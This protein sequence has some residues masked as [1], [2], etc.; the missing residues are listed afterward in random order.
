MVTDM[1]GATE[2]GE[3]PPH[4]GKILRANVHF[5]LAGLAG[6]MALLLI[7]T[8][9]RMYRTEYPLS[10]SAIERMPPELRAAVAMDCREA[11]RG[12]IKEALRQAGPEYR[13]I[14]ET[15]NDPRVR[16]YACGR[17][18]ELLAQ[19]GDYDAAGDYFVQCHQLSRDQ[20]PPGK[21]NKH[22]LYLAHGAY[23]LAGKNT[24]ELKTRAQDELEDDEKKAFFS[25]V[26]RLEEKWPAGEDAP[27]KKRRGPPK[28][29]HP[30]VWRRLAPHADWIAVSTAALIL[31]L[32]GNAKRVPLG[33]CWWA[34]PIAP[35]MALAALYCALG[36]PL[37]E[38]LAF[39]MGRFSAASFALMRRPS[40]VAGRVLTCVI[41]ASFLAPAITY[42]VLRRRRDL[43]H[44]M[45]GRVTVAKSFCWL[46]LL[47]GAGYVFRS[48]VYTLGRRMGLVHPP[49]V[50]SPIEPLSG[51]MAV[52]IVVG[53]ISLML[54]SPI[55]QE[56]VF[57]GLV[58]GA[59]QARFP[60][61]VAVILSS[62]VFAL[63]HAGVPSWSWA[64]AINYG[65]GGLLY[66]V[67]YNRTGGLL[68]P[69]ILH[70]VWNVAAIL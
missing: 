9:Y 68:A 18:A 11:Y 42:S 1:R 69:I 4:D 41:C 61:V 8:V 59:L 65:V 53:A 64:L 37:R 33:S 56:I 63:A 45:L 39:A 29:R 12:R 26:Q 50:W 52:W 15:T 54:A 22:W 21:S 62:A 43:L 60:G 10:K 48:G 35:A 49:A 44:M 46:A 14:I 67:L 38:V 31:A 6:M 34:R 20:A 70:M 66:G 28:G 58:Q 25:G 51:Q 13:R 27:Q 19:T 3:R 32:V 55:V 40:F 23:S 36:G 5:A 57:R 2:V 47:G 30:D 16:L 17:L 24:D 7:A